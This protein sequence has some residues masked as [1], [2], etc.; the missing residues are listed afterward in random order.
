[1]AEN[2]QKMADY[3]AERDKA[4]DAVADELVIKGN[5]LADKIYDRVM[6]CVHP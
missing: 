2:N 3:M 4:I 6:D 1:M 5:E